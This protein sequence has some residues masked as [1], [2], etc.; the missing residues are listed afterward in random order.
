MNRPLRGPLNDTAVDH[1]TDAYETMDWL[2]KKVPESNGQVG[3][4]QCLAGRK[5][6]ADFAAPG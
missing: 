4:Q 1:S 5:A 6:G 3:A 2:V